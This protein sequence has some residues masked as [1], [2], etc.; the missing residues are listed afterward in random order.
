VFG[1][2]PKPVGAGFE[3]KRFDFITSNREG[4]F[5]GTPTSRAA[6]TRRETLQDDVPSERRRRSVPTARSTWPTGSMP[7]WVATPTGTNPP[8]E[9][10]TA[11]PARARIRRPLRWTSPRVDG[12]IAALK[13]PAVNVRGSAHYAL[14]R[15]GN[16]ALPAITKLLKDSNPYVRA[17]AVWLLAASSPKGTKAVEALLEDRDASMRVVAFRA[18]RRVAED[19]NIAATM[20]ANAGAPEWFLAASLRMAVGRVARGAS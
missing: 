15:F 13:S 8:R 3:L 2:F 4:E 14:Q 10:S 1:Y 7:A 16:D 11:S 5:A 17:R 19:H 6:A 9:R 12:A 18:L 20:P